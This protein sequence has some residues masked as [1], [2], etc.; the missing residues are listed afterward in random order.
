MLRPAKAILQPYFHALPH[1]THKNPPIL[2]YHFYH[3]NTVQPKW[4]TGKDYSYAY[5]YLTLILL[6]V[7]QYKNYPFTANLTAIHIFYQGKKQRH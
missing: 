2:M 6:S 3:E 1:F 7:N 4:A 5:T